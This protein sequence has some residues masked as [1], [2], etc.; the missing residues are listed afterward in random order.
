MKAIIKFECDIVELAE[1]YP[2]AVANLSPTYRLAL[3]Y[4][5]T[6]T[7]DGGLETPHPRLSRGENNG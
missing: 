1:R 3:D 4:I 6:Q 2:N 7:R 5:R